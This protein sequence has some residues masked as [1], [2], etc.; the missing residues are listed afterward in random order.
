[1][2]DSPERPACECPNENPAE[3]RAAAEERLIRPMVVEE[4]PPLGWRE[5]LAI[6]LLVVLGDMTIFRGHGFAGYAVLFFAAPLLLAM[7]S[8]RPRC[9]ALSWLIGA[10]LVVLAVKLAWCGSVLLIVAGFALVVAF[11]VALSGSCPYVIEVGVFASQLLVAG[12]EGLIHYWRCLERRSPAIHRTKWLN[13]AMPLVALVAFGFCFILANPNLLKL[14]GEGVEWIGNWLR[15]SVLA[16]SPSVW[17]VLFWLGVLWVA[18]GLLRPLAKRT[19]FYDQMP[20][21]EA[22][23][24]QEPSPA[25]LYAAFRN[26]LV[27]VIVLFVVYLAFE[28]N[29]LW[30]KEF[31]KGF[32]YSGYAHEGA[33]W[34]TVA[35]ALATGVLSLVF[36]GDVLRDPR[37]PTLRRLAWLWSF[38]NIVLAA[39]VY[40]RLYIYI[41]FNG[42]TFKRMIGIFGIS[43]VVV[44]FVLVVWKIVH[45]HDFLWLL[46]RHLWTLAI[47]T[48]LFAVT[49]VDMIVTH[50]NVGRIMSGDPAPSVQISEHPIDAEGVAA[51]L[52]LLECKDTTIRDGVTA[53]LAQ[54][55]T[56]AQSLAADN[57]NLGWTTFQLADRTMLESLDRASDGWKSYTADPAK[58]WQAMDRFKKYAY[59]WY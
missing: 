56:A 15:D 54:R 2:N 52:P 13:L 42:M 33:A 26:T 49:P 29:T 7:G 18:I 55:Q 46:R 19:S 35:L 23:D 12:Y 10:M 17:E 9:G 3:R 53:M 38:E 14:F 31:P 40:H 39:A 24:A 47:A 44:G 59:Q 8:P 22:A 48:Y 4:P 11:A 41:G 34:L 6:A 5:S 21:D 20:D 45:N 30:F 57:E 50:Y 51:L 32:Y 37:L 36:R 1:M 28:F 25:A 58:R 43:A 16:F 27:T